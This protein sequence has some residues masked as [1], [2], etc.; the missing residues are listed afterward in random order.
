MNE[1]DVRYWGTVPV[2][3]DPTNPDIDPPRPEVPVPPTPGPG[4]PEPPPGPLQADPVEPG[5][6]PIRTQHP[7]LPPGP[8]YLTVGTLLPDMTAAAQA[9]ASRPVLPGGHQQGERLAHVVLNDSFIEDV[10]ADGIDLYL[11]ALVAA[12]RVA[13]SEPERAVVEELEAQLAR[14]GIAEAHVTCIRLAGQLVDAKGQLHVSTNDGTVLY[15]S[16]ALSPDEFEPT[17]HGAEDPEDPQ[18]PVYS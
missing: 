14:V 8:D 13:E 5:P 17:V 7:P 9:G 10:G 6:T 12:A 1:A 4:S 16:P 11:E 15:G 18:R 3:P 2:P